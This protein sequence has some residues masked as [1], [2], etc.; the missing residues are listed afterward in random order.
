MRD[1]LREFFK[2]IRGITGKHVFSSRSA[3]P[4]AMVYISDWLGC[5]VRGPH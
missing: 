4:I 1:P 5:K 2:S 3:F